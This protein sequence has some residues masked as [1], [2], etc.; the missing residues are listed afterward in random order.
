MTSMSGGAQSANFVAARTVLPPYDAI[1]AC[2]TVP[3][4]RPPHH[5]AFASVVTPISTPMVA[6]ATWAA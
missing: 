5:D 2:G 6:P 1:S 3:I 4:P